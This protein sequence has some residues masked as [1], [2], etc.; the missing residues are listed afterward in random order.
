VRL[1]RPR[2]L[3]PAP[4]PTHLFAAPSVRLAACCSVTPTSLLFDRL[5]LLCPLRCD[6]RG[7][8]RHLLP[9]P[10]PRGDPHPT[11]STTR[12][13]TQPLPLPSPNH[14]FFRLEVLNHHSKARFRFGSP[15]VLTP[16]LLRRRSSPRRAPQSYSSPAS[17]TASW[18]SSTCTRCGTPSLAQ[19]RRS[20]AQPRRARVASATR[21]A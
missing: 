1:G 8:R 14:P 6:F 11:P 13:A 3:G 17:W 4:L 19:P 20:L 5:L 16:P 18:I 7:R 10:Q 2:R 21:P 9:P 12:V 15:P